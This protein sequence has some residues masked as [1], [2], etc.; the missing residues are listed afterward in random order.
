MLLLLSH[1]GL[2]STTLRLQLFLPCD[3]GADSIKPTYKDLGLI[4]PQRSLGQLGFECVPSDQKVS[5]PDREMIIY[6]IIW[7]QAGSSGRIS[8]Q[9][10]APPRAV[11]IQTSH[12]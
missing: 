6:R 9:S 4:E 7:N 8:E 1:H 3:S 12:I 2:T 10:T 11:L 5:F